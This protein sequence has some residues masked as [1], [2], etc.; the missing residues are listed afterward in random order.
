MAAHREYAVSTM[1]S[2]P[3]LARLMVLRHPVP[4]SLHGYCLSCLTLSPHIL[5]PLEEYASIDRFDPASYYPVC[6]RGR[7]IKNIS[8]RVSPPNGNGLILVLKRFKL[9]VDGERS[10][11]FPPSV[12]F[13]FRCSEM[14]GSIFVSPDPHL[15]IVS[16]APCAVAV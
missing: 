5:Y 6:H 9:F 13:T 12:L 14:C 7:N 3:I 11:Q 2:P 10:D 4:S 16:V 15:G 1:L 8:R